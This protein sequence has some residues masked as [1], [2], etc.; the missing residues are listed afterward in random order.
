[1]NPPTKPSDAQ[2]AAEFGQ[3]STARSGSNQ[4]ADQDESASNGRSR[5]TQGPKS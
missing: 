1:M 5:S 2:S 4:P 3:R